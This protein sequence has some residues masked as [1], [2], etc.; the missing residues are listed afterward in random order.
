MLELFHT[1]FYVPIYNLL[2]FLVDII[3]GGDAGVAVILATIFIKIVLLPLSIQATKTQKGMK[4][5][6]PQLKELREKY[7]EDK[8]KQALEMLALY[9]EHNIKPFSTMFIALIQIPILIYLFLVFQNE[10]FTAINTEILYSFIPTPEVVSTLFLGSILVT[11]SSLILAILAAAAQFMHSYVAIKIPKAE[12]KEGETPSFGAEFGRSMA[13][14]ARYFLPL[15]IGYFAYVLGGALA[16]YF[17]T[18][19]VFQTLQEV[20]VTRT[21]KDKKA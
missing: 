20:L 17:I 1:I 13:I 18:S 9:K 6:E 12:H 5:I 11:S 16:L 21:V 14:N 15:L 4:E 7:K 19:S 3:P 8:E 2:I 10:S